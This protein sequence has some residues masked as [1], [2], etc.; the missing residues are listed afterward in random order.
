L[1]ERLG[2]TSLITVLPAAAKVDGGLVPQIAPLIKPFLQ[3][4]PDP[5]LPNNQFT[6]PF[7]Q[8]NTDNYGQMR[9]DQTFS[10]SDTAFARYT[11][12]DDKLSMPFST[13][14]PAATDEQEPVR[15]V[16]ENHVFSPALL[17]TFR[18]S[19]S[20]TTR[21]QD[22]NDTGLS[23]PQFSFVPGQQVGILN[24]GGIAKW[25]PPSTS[26]A[27]QRQNIFTWSDDIFYTKGR[28][29]LKFGALINRYQQY[30]LSTQTARGQINF[31]NV[32]S[33][34]AGPAERI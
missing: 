27:H 7:S 28:H 3:Y 12:D 31:A 30:D 19:F 26:P 23:G 14:E 9:V 2:L 11:I 10:A 21:S 1:R 17:N 5:N 33:F 16:V 24:I 13:A 15:H 34:F 22:T 32:T 20:R 8:P 29:A 4:F 18:F 6:Y 25:G